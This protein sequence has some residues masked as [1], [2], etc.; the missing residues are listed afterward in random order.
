[1]YNIRADID[2]LLNLIGK[3]QTLVTVKSLNIKGRGG[4]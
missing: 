2:Y 3:N 4:Y 1:M